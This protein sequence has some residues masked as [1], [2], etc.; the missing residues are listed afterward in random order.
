MESLLYKKLATLERCA[1]RDNEVTALQFA[2]ARRL[3]EAQS[4]FIFIGRQSRERGVTKCL[5]TLDKRNQELSPKFLV[6]FW[7]DLNFIRDG[8]HCKI[9]LP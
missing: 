3:R 8:I 4:I 5:G 6:P 7:M 2:R 9:P 1:A